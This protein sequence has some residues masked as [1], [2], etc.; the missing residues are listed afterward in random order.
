MADTYQILY[1]GGTG[2][3]TEKKSR[4]IAHTFPVHSEEEALSHIAAIKKEYWDARHNCYAFV[5]GPRQE[6]QRFSDDG[7]PA[8]TAG[9]PILEVLLR[10]EIH[11]CLIVVTRYFGGTLLGTGGLVRAYQRSS[12]EGLA[13]STIIPRGTG[14]LYT[15][16]ADYNQ[17]GRIRHYLEDR[18]LPLLEV[19]YQQDVE[20]DVILTEETLDPVQKAA[21][22]LTSGAAVFTEL[23]P[24]T[25][26]ILDGEVFLLE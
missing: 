17:F 20:L 11:D 4:F 1:R 14:T 15:I 24:V 22:D 23:G 16:S 3:I 25:F 26:G 18:K 10:E 8:G 2:E 7:E 6:L 9:K 21:A 12:Q 19:R 13:A 5:C